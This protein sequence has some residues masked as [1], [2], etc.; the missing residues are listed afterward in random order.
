MNKDIVREK[1]ERIKGKNNHFRFN[2]SRNRIEEFD[3]VVTCTYP[4]I[5]IIKDDELKLRAFSYNDV[6]TSS[7]EIIDV[8]K[9]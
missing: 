7:L 6:I 9:T 4:A 5:F 8:K 2:G 1:L 3:G